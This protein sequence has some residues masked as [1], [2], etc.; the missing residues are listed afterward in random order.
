MTSVRQK[1]EMQEYIESKLSNS[2][3]AV[4]SHS[5]SALGIQ[6]NYLKVGSSG[7][8]LLVDRA[9]NKKDFNTLY[10]HAGIYSERWDNATG[11]P[12]TRFAV[13]FFK[14]GKTYFR[15]AAKEVTF[16]QKLELSLK[17]YSPQEIHRIISCQFAEK[18][19]IGRRRGR[20]QYYQPDSERLGQA[21]VSF[22]YR[23]VWLD[24][25]HMPQYEIDMLGIRGRIKSVEEP[26][27]KSDKLYIWT[28]KEESHA[29]LA[30]IGNELIGLSE[31][32]RT[33]LTAC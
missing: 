17:K 8:V 20:I 5:D 3:E 19:M 7:L 1:K 27:A 2:G 31:E 26:I 23:P 12:M 32:D 15:S 30:L 14:D 28:A 9:F 10:L 33:Q 22:E 4:E 16:K 6:A 11:K 24:Y 25:S 13:V 21:L 18:A 29:N